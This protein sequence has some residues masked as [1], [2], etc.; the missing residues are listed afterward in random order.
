MAAATDPQGYLATIGG[1]SVNNTVVNVTSSKIV[2]PATFYSALSKRM[3]KT[4]TVF[5]KYKRPFEIRVSSMVGKTHSGEKNFKNDLYNFTRGTAKKTVESGGYSFA[6]APSAYKNNNQGMGIFEVSYSSDKRKTSFFFAENSRYSAGDYH[7]SAGFNPY[8]AMNEAYGV[9]N[10]LKFDRL[11]FK[12]GFM[13]GENGL[14]DGDKAYNDRNFDSRSYAFNAEASYEVS[15]ALTLGVVSGMLSED[16]SV[17]GLNGYGAF[18]IKDSSTF[19]TG[20]KLAYSPFD[21]WSFSG[22]YYHGLTNPEK[23]YESMISM[24]E[25]YSDS[26]AFDGHYKLNKTDIIGLQISSPLR[27]YKGHADFDIATGRDNYSD[28]I[29]RRNIRSDLKPGAREYKFALYHNREISDNL[30]LKGEIAARL[31][32]EHQS[33]A[34]ADYRAMFGLSW[35]F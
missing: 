23:S 7:E 13:T 20:V 33:D 30:S 18:S 4:M 25:L 12:F 22:A 1:N 10:E 26:F 8:L 2:V 6:F 35:A 31:N 11:G 15:P 5:D 24:S 14:Y 32:P 21:N 3:P 28:K 34:K 17:L 9:E 16:D 27:V 29:Y 19:F